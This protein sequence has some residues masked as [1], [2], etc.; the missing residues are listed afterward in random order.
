VIPCGAG[1]NP[2]AVDTMAIN[3]L[4]TGINTYESDMME[5]METNERNKMERMET[6][7]RNKSIDAF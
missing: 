6:N 4:I 2:A 5:R 1:G 7:E 3:P